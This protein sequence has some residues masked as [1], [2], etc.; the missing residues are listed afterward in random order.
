VRGTL[1][2]EVDAAASGVRPRVQLNFDRVRASFDGLRGGRDSSFRAAAT[3]L[4]LLAPLL[5][6]G[7]AVVRA[8][9]F[10][11]DVSAAN[12]AGDDWLTYK[13]LALSVIDG[14]LAMPGA[15]GSY[16]AIP[17]GFLYVYFLAFLFSL[18]GA[19][20]AYVYVVQSF[21]C[22]ATVSVTYAAVKRKFSPAVGLIFI[23][24]LAGLMYVDVYRAIAFRLLSEN[25]YFPLS[26][27]ALYFLLPLFEA[28]TKRRLAF[29]FFAGLTLGL[30]VLTRPSFVLSA[31]AVLS[32]IFVHSRLRGVTLRAPLAAALGGVVGVSGN[33]VRDYLAGGRATFA[34]VSDTRD[35]RRIWELPPLVFAQALASRVLFTFGIP[36]LMSPAYRIRP[37]WVVLW[38][39]FV[40]YLPAKLFMRRPVQIWEAALYAYVVCYI[41]PVIAVADIASYGG[42]MVSTILPVSLVLCFRLVEEAVSPK[43]GR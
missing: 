34:I 21:L 31:A 28:A 10:V 15:S 23:V 24:A 39:A 36:Q 14:G 3:V 4:A 43:H 42:R 9:P 12:S 32:V 29:S 6:L 11:D 19:N 17:H 22:G 1:T 37:H 30:I 27:V 2:P 25:L 13:T 8:Y 26:A 33:L 35:W 20:S 40:A 7:L 38:L 41:V 16:G 5:F 18:F